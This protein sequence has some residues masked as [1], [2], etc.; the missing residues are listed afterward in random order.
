MSS[1]RSLGFE[2]YQIGG[3][4]DIYLYQAVPDSSRSSLT[5]EISSGAS[6]P[7]MTWF[8]LM[9]SAA[10]V[11][12]SSVGNSIMMD[13]PGR[14]ASMSMAAALLS[15]FQIDGRSVA[16]VGGVK[17]SLIPQFSYFLPDIILSRSAAVRR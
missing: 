15:F 10:T 6:V 17:S 1:W 13:Y 7:I 5:I 9:P 14:R 11:I 8:P 3:S 4:G 2:P 12:R 16:R